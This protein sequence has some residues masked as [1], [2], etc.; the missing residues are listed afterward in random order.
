MRREN[1]RRHQLVEPAA[2]ARE[3]LAACDARVPL[4]TL[5][6]RARW[7]VIFDYK[8]RLHGNALALAD[9]AD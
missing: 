8:G 9:T 5:H 7:N 4:G 6:G 3:I 1:P 2:G